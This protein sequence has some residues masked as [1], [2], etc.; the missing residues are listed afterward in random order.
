MPW[1]IQRRVLKQVEK[2]FPGDVQPPTW[3]DTVRIARDVDDQFAA[4]K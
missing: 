3:A 4:D 2:E 1:E